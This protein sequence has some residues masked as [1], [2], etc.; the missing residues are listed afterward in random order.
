M[1]GGAQME[2]EGHLFS[3]IDAYR[4]AVNLAPH[5]SLYRLKLATALRA[6]DPAGTASERARL[7]EE[8]YGTEPEN[9][10]LHEH[11][12]IALLDAHQG[13]AAT[14]ELARAAALAPTFG[15][16][17]DAYGQALAQQRNPTQALS[18]L[19]RAIHLDPSS[20]AYLNDRGNVLQML[21]RTPEAIEAYRAALQRDPGNPSAQ[22]NLARL[23]APP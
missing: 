22:A 4:T 20:A 10:F 16:F 1:G 21:G 8:G 2:S 6:S 5:E 13:E 7:L 17:Q 14:S 15:E 3:A 12:G 19:D 11:R 18:A 23:G 9:P